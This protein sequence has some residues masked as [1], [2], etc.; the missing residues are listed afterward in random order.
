MKPSKAFW[1]LCCSWRKQ[2]ERERRKPFFFFFF[3]IS[4]TGEE[5]ETGGGGGGGGGKMQAILLNKQCMLISGGLLEERE[6][7]KERERERIIY[8]DQFQLLHINDAVGSLCA[9][10]LT[11]SVFDDS[12]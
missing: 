7:E 12:Y 10:R 9:S 1:S 8:T 3:F 5:R 2:R 6:R 11:S 4:G